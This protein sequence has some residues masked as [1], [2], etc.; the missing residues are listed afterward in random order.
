MGWEFM[1]KTKDSGKPQA[2]NLSKEELLTLYRALK[3]NE[4]NYSDGKA[5][6]YNDY[7]D[8]YEKPIRKS[9]IGNILKKISSALPDKEV[10]ETNKDFLR[11]KYRTFNND[12]D[13]KVYS[14]LKK[15]LAGQIT[16]AIEYFD[17]DSAE[18]IKREIDVYHTT[19]RYTEAYCHLRKEDRTFRT[20]R[21]AKAKLTDKK[22]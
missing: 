16:V 20:S 4:E 9:V 12:V 21:I 18:F 8:D 10:T 14:T 17:M 19:A 3:S 13:Q 22:Y 7:Y 1:A 6:I 15:G 11:R 2:I 5:E